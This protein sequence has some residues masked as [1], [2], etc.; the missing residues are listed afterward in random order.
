MLNVKNILSETATKNKLEIG[1]LQFPDCELSPESIQVVMISEVPPQ[2]P[3]DGFYNTSPTSDYMKSTLGLFNKAGVSV[4]SIQDILKL[5]IYI[6]TAVKSPKTSYAV[7]TDVIKNHLPL[8][9]AELALFPNL[10]VIMLMGDVAKKA[11]NMIAKKQTK[12]NIIPSE[13][14]YKI[15]G[16]EF[17]WGD[18]QVFPSYII[19]GGNIL[20]EKSKCEMIAD[21]IRHMMALIQA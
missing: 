13:S 19:T 18:I 5:G 20:I 3:E 1:G 21:D 10:K 11:V 17:Y 8:L 9:E 14:T 2:N 6:T 12:K 4:Q 15:R 16:G 7:D